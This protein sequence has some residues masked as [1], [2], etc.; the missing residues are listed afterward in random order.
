MKTLVLFFSYGI[1]LDDW[2]NNG[3][4]DRE[5]NI[6][7]KFLRYFDKIYFI[8]YGKNDLKYKNLFPEN[9]L[10]VPK[11][12]GIPN[13]LYSFL[14]PLIL[15]K[16][17]GLASWIKTNQIMGSW[18]AIIAKLLYSKKL[19]LRTGY[20]E[21]LSGKKN[22]K[23]LFFSL[24]ERIAYFFSDIEIVT[25][26][27]QLS[28]IKKRYRVKEAYLIPNGIDIELFR[29]KLVSKDQS[30]LNLIFV[31]RL[32]PEKNI[33][34]LLKAISR[35][36]RVH[37]TIIGTGG[38]KNKIEKIKDNL[39]LDLNIIDS[40]PNSEL[41][42]I[43]NNSDVYIQPSLYEGNPKTILEAMSCGLPVISCDVE[44][45]NNIIEHKENG[46]LCA[47]DA[48]SISAAIKDVLSNHKL[49]ETMGNNAAEFIKENYNLNK[50]IEKEIE[51]Y[52]K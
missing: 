42:E 27:F 12:Y 19:A 11:R 22:I 9:I 28:Y 47:T 46:Y 50:M 14:S 40:I 35:L 37:L 6:Y 24:I 13:I 26:Q 43:Y 5:I 44:G 4:L 51:I 25:S 39:N 41:P 52:D 16:E 18:S 10:I 2:N 48:Q 3:T 8:T 32:E 33:L 30:K 36:D 17:I 49:Q 15:R 45:I 21:S 38:L 7:K 34:N 31:G 23:K 20:T 1:K 29:P